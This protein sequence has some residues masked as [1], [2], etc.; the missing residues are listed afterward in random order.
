MTT[1]PTHYVT[2]TDRRGNTIRGKV[3]YLQ[4]HAE[5]WRP[6]SAVVHIVTS[7]W[8]DPYIYS[9]IYTSPAQ[10]V[11]GT[12]N[13]HSYATADDLWL[14]MGTFTPAQGDSAQAP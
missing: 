10:S 3:V 8:L 4:P 9:A 12:Y 1:P 5:R 11:A 14:F 2:V 6:Q 13:V 7:D